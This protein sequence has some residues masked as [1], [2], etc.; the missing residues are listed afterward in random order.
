[1]SSAVPPSDRAR[2][3]D[4]PA[5][6]ELDWP[7]LLLRLTGIDLRLC[8]ACHQPTL[9]RLPLGLSLQPARAPPRLE[10]AAA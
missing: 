10:G 5:D 7:V 8:P 6:E 9:R 3:D 1:M 2:A 4:E